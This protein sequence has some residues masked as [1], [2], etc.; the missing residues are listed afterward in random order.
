MMAMGSIDDI[1][2]RIV[3]WIFNKLSI[4]EHSPVIL[5]FEEGIVI[6]ISKAAVV[7]K[8]SPELVLE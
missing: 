2:L 3:E 5:Y 1:Q 8:D 7:D 4:D 6:T